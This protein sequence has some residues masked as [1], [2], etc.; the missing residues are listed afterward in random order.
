MTKLQLYLPYRLVATDA[1]NATT[2]PEVSY[3]SPAAQ[4]G[5]WAVYV[6]ALL[7]LLLGL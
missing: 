4:I 5:Q 3:I 2:R 7:P 6:L 1:A